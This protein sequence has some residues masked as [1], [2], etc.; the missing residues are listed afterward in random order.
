[1]EAIQSKF[2]KAY[3]ERRVEKRAIQDLSLS[4]KLIRNWYQNPEFKLAYNE[5]RRFILSTKKCVYCQKIDAKDK[6]RNE[7]EK[8]VQ[9]KTGICLQCDS[10]RVMKKESKTMEAKLRFLWKS[11]RVRV[12]PGG[13]RWPVGDLTYAELID[14]F[15]SQNGLCYYTG[16]P[17]QYNSETRG[18]NV[19][20]DRKNPDDNYT[21]SNVV[22]CS[23]AINKMKND[24]PFDRFLQT[25]K[26]IA[27]RLS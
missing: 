10:N 9:W 27:Q 13:R 16:E 22:L 12:R 18:A 23:W 6:F 4:W 7:S 15:N 11:T 3:K 17:L 8:R 2:L 21:K 1:M 26:T 19:S 20:I 24:M 14:I 25:C 5:V